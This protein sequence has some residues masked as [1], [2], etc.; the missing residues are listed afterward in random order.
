MLGFSRVRT[1]SI[2]YGVATR[3]STEMS[4]ASVVHSVTY[5]LLRKRCWGRYSRGPGVHAAVRHVKQGK[6]GCHAVVACL[7]ST[8]FALIKTT[9]ESTVI[10]VVECMMKS[11]CVI[12]R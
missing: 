11:I 1:S 2:T 3:L 8:G 9:V 4:V 10:I 6:R 12:R 5:Q 7:F